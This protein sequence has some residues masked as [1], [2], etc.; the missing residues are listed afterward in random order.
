M[1][2]VGEKKKKKATKLVVG[3]GHV[4]SFGSIGDGIAVVCC[5]WIDSDSDDGWAGSQILKKIREAAAGFHDASLFVPCTCARVR[6]SLSQRVWDWIAW[7][8]WDGGGGG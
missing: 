3:A 4:S 7:G 5:Y 1:W 2:A 8:G 6:V